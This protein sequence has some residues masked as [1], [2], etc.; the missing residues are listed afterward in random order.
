MTETFFIASLLLFFSTVPLYRVPSEIATQI[1]IFPGKNT[2]GN[3]PMPDS[4]PSIPALLQISTRFPYESSKICKHYL[5]QN[6]KE[7]IL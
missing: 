3:E 6:R 2:V 5:S 1:Q 4:A 7:E